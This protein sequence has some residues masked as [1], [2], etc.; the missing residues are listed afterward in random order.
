VPLVVSTTAEKNVFAFSVV[1]ANSLLT[2]NS[3]KSG[4]EGAKYIISLFLWKE[5]EEREDAREIECRA[6]FARKVRGVRWATPQSKPFARET[7]SEL[8]I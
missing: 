4:V 5:V 7:G 2:L 3:I 8:P 1:I 6:T